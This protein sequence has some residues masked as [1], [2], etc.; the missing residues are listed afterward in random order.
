[1][2]KRDMVSSREQARR[3]IKSGAVLVDG[4]PAQKPGAMIT[5]RQVIDILQH[6]KYVGRGGQKLERALDKFGIDVSRLTACDIGAG[7]GGFCHCLLERGAAKIYAVDVG[8][9]QL[10]RRISDHSRVVNLEG[11]NFRH[12]TDAIPTGLDFACV[13]VSFISLDKILPNLY[14]ILKPSANAVCLIKPQFEAGRDKLNKHGLVTDPRVH[15]QALEL[16]AEYISKAGF[17]LLGLCHSP[18]KGGSG[19][20][21]YLAHIRKDDNLTNFDGDIKSIVAKAHVELK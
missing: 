9:S 8:H 1:M 2:L 14:N 18:I 6:E 19:N 21:E 3:L 7:T 11:V 12:Q 17:S 10:D 20:I 13:D 5:E 15:T 4:Q 16:V